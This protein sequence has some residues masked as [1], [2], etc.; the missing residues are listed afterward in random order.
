M[1]KYQGS[2]ETQEGFLEKARK[3]HG[4]F[5]DYSK[6]KYVDCNTKVIIGCPVH[7]DF[8]QLPW[9]HRNGTKCRK[10]SV[11]SPVST[12]EYIA[13]ARKVHGDFYDYSKVVYGNSFSKL[14][15]GCR[16]HGD[17]TKL[18]YMHLGGQ[19]CKVCGN[20]RKTTTQADFI[21]RS[22]KAHGSKYDYSKVEYTNNYTPVTIVCPE[23]GEFNQKPASHLRRHGC[24]ICCRVANRLTR[25]QFIEK[26]NA[27]HGNK[28]DY[29]R[30]KFTVTRGKVNI[31]CPEH[32]KFRVQANNHLNGVGCTICS[33]KPK[34]VFNTEQFIKRAKEVHG[35]LF[36]YSGVNYT[37]SAV[38]VLIHCK[39]DGHGGFFQRPLNH[40]SGYGCPICS[41]SKGEA[42]I[43]RL[44]LAQGVKF[45]RQYVLPEVNLKLRY[46][47]YLP[48]SRT[49]IE[50]HGEQHYRYIPFFHR[51]GEDDLLAQKNRDDLIVHL[52]REFKYNYLEFNYRQ[53]TDLS[54]SDFEHLVLSKL[55]KLKPKSLFKPR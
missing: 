19:G 6:T 38:D 48:E 21:A 22:I 39:K 31:I 10:C 34:R 36:D 7:G 29:S 45:E 16:L 42:A 35:D 23:H 37:R 54:L 26:A 15:I 24:L 9:P 5:Y 53:L 47:F 1:L 55:N 46:D 30:V 40:L 18:A 11:A 2:R 52:A 17:F 28:Y 33:N 12:E 50:F 13:K 27:V 51:N 25:T 20:L 8:E 4:D 14:I 49:L 3:T 32:G 44:L 41:E 43:R